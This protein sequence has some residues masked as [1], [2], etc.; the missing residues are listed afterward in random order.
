MFG[1]FLRQKLA[2]KPYTVV[3]DGTQRRDILYVTDVA[4]AFRHRGVGVATLGR[5]WARVRP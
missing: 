4:R 2:G 1:V 3:G 5:H